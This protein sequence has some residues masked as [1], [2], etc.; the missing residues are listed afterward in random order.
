MLCETFL[1]D[2]I[3]HIFNIPGYS[4]LFKNRK[5]SSR[6]GVALYIKNN[7]KHKIRD[8]IAINI[9]NEFESIFV[10]IL[11]DN[12]YSNTLVG[13]IYRV[14]NT[15]EKNSLERYQTIISRINQSKAASLIGTD[16]NFDL[17]KIDTHN[18]SLDLFN[19]FTAS[20]HLPVILRPTRIT[21]SSCT[22]IDN[23]YTN[24]IKHSS[25]YFSGIITTDI[26]D[27]LPVIFITS[28]K[29][30]VSKGQHKSFT[31]RPTNE[32]TLHNIYNH[33]S[34]IDWTYLNTLAINDAWTQFHN[35]LNNT[36]NQYAPLKTMRLSP[37]QIIMQPW[38]STGLV[39]SSRTLDKLYRK[40][41]GKSK[42][43]PSHINFITFRNVYS[44]LKRQH[45]RNY[46]SDL[47]KTYSNDI[48]KQWQILRKIIGKENDKSAISD[49]FRNDTHFIT[50][51]KT[52]ANS[53]C[54]YFSN[55]GNIFASKIPAPNTPFNDYLSKSNAA[56]KSIYIAPTDP[57]EI[58]N[59]L[60]SMKAKKKHRT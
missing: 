36:I 1:R 29:Q 60:N 7:I 46:Y 48:K 11:K 28:K 44:G 25:S 6:G 21:H 47:F 38:M 51:P 24:T 35:T 41:L 15:N 52:I 23:I 2:S 18:S 27:H 54:E 9:D 56:N 45:K 42:E 26:S 16:Q 39:Q 37:K 32:Q 3:S 40:Q 20:G 53:F 30:N 14:P 31:Y 49:R 19:S 58:L 57:Y 13:E 10:E 50:D 4:F 22:L 34:N 33:L 43:H 17:L 8:D 12:N 5:L 55:V 59:I